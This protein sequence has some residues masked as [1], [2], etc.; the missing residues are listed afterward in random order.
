MSKWY[1]N[2]IRGKPESNL[3]LRERMSRTISSNI[4]RHLGI[5]KFNEFGQII[6]NNPSIIVSQHFFR[7]AMSNHSKKRVLKRLEKRCA[8]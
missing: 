4:I 5:P 3:G 8:Y 2:N 1:D 6:A 7:N